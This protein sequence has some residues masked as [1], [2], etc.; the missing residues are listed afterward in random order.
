MGLHN[1]YFRHFD[2]RV[3]QKITTHF[4]MVSEIHCSA[5]VILYWALLGHRYIILGTSWPFLCYVGHFLAILM[6]YW[7]LL[8]HCYIILGTSWTLLYYIVEVKLPGLSRFCIFC[9]ESRRRFLLL[10]LSFY[11]LVALHTISSISY[12]LTPL[13][14][15]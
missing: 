11:K 9:M 6:L 8:G 7:A 5:I 4:V 1:A 3:F 10:L 13:A 15:V 12:K 2:Q 14:Y